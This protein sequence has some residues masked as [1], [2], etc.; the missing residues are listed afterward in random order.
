ME[1]FNLVTY[2]TV[3]YWKFGETVTRLE[4]FGIIFGVAAIMCFE[5]A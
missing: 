1:V 3:S 4:V 2:L 5:L